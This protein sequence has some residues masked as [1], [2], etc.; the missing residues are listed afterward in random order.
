MELGQSIEKKD[1]F[2]TGIPS[3]V[4]GIRLL[5]ANIKALSNVSASLYVESFTKLIFDELPLYI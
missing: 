3:K 5:N 2:R 4:S 1:G